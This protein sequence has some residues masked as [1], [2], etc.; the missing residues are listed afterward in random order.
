[1]GS[2]RQIYVINRKNQAFGRLFLVFYFF[3]VKNVKILV[4]NFQ[5]TM[6]LGEKCP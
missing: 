3:V 2:I 1:M 4:S 6:Q 5:K